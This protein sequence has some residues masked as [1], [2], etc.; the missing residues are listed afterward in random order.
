VNPTGLS[1]TDFNT[2]VTNAVMDDLIESMQIKN[3]LET[4][5]SQ[6]TVVD[7][8]NAIKK[9]LQGLQGETTPLSDYYI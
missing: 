9:I 5:G 4:L 7:K 6:M 1:V 2:E 8:S 3:K